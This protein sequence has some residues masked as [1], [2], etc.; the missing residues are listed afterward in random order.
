MS[1]QKK[2]KNIFIFLFQ[3][4]LDFVALSLKALKSLVF[5]KK[6]HSID[7]KFAF[8]ET[9]FEHGP[10]SFRDK[11]T[12]IKLGRS[13]FVPF[14]YLLSKTKDESTSQK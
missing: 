14:L 12:G 6:M 10:K 1:I 4:L 7:S 13:I 3:S 5:F 11:P 8:L 2:S 9:I